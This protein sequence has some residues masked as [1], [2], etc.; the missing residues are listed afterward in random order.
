MLKADSCSELAATKFPSSEQVI[1]LALGQP[2]LGGDVSS[3]QHLVCCII[4]AMTRTY[5]WDTPSGRLSIRQFNRGRWRL[6]KGED[7]LG[8][9]ETPEEALPAVAKLGPKWKAPADLDDWQHVT[10]RLPPDL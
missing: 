6:W 1:D 3:G 10:G 8:S 7:F 5:W 9:F 2:E 4:S